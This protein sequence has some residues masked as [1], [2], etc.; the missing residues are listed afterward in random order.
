MISI[1]PEVFINN[2]GLIKEG[3]LRMPEQFII[4]TESQSGD[5][6]TI[7]ITKPDEI[8]AAIKTFER[9]AAFLKG[10]TEPKA[11]TQESELPPEIDQ[12]LPTAQQLTHGKR[13][14]YRKG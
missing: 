3:Y 14:N 1:T 11:S 6:N 8:V 7:A 4:T 5:T 12:W 9:R 13:I 10:I 2:W